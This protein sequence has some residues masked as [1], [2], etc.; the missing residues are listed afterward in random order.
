MIT[1]SV[2]RPPLPA[3]AR[4]GFNDG[5]LLLPPT[6]LN[7]RVPVVVVDHAY[8]GDPTAFGLEPFG[9]CDPRSPLPQTDLVINPYGALI[10]IRSTSTATILASACLPDRRVLPM[11]ASYG[12]AALIVGST[13]ELESTWAALWT[14]FVGTAKIN[15]LQGEQ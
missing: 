5:W 8:I 6:F 11:L 7:L 12:A 13:Y 4:L 14:M 1:G 2:Q 9:A 10:I 15:N 3:V